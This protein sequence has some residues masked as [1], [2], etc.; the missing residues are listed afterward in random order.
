MNFPDLLTI[1]GL[2]QVRPEPPFTPGFEAA[3]TVSAVGEGVV[4]LS[5]G[6][7]VAVTG[8]VG[9]FAEQWLV[10][11]TSCLPLPAGVSFEAGATVSVTYGTSYHA[12]KQRARLEPGETL[13]VL[14]AAG[15]V[16][17]A[18]VE[19]AAHMGAIVIA[20]ASTDEKLAFCRGIGATEIVN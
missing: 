19:I 3:G 11:A 12:L 6:D 7:R 1:R 17:S 18:A 15:G 2:Y 13:L 20:A 5:V 9:A 4:T 8:V 16:G 14:G 10:P